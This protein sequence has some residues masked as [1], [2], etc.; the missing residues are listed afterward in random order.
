MDELSRSVAG[1][2]LQMNSPR[3]LAVCLLL[4]H[5]GQSH[6][7]QHLEAASFLAASLAGVLAFAFA[8]PGADASAAGHFYAAAAPRMASPPSR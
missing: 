7:A 2:R 4:G 8:F 5:V 1:Y 6:F 3:P